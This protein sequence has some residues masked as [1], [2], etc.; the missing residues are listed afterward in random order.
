MISKLCAWGADR[1]EAVRRMRR[2]LSEY[3][4][5]GV[6]TTVNFHLSVMDNKAF[7]DG[8]LHTHFI[9][10]EFPDKNFKGEGDAEH[11][12]QAAAVSACLYD[13]LENSKIKTS[14]TEPTGNQS[15]WKAYGRKAGVNRVPE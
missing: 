12:L 3:R 7:Q 9:D 14:L 5:S 13:F 6:D 8:I 1:P 11:I 2:A 15:N 10:E 4:I